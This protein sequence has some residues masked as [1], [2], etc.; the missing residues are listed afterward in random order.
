MKPYS[1]QIPVLLCLEV[2]AESE[3]QARAIGR[4]LAKSCETEREM[5]FEDD[6]LLPEAC[7]G[8]DVWCPEVPPDED[9]FVEELVGDA[10]GGDDG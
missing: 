4:T 8:A 10:A 1:V 5:A 9:L 3:E 7:S 6:S 2:E